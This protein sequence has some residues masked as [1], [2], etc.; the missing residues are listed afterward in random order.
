MHKHQILVMFSVRLDGE[1]EVHCDA[2]EGLPEEQRDHPRG[3]T[4]QP[5]KRK[6]RVCR[7]NGQERPT[8]LVVFV[9]VG[10]RPRARPGEP[11]R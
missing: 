3:R 2:A 4:E 9:L 5:E 1:G 6:R 7:V 11:R 10:Q 8:D